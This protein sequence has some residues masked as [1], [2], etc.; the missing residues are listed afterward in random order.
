MCRC[1]SLHTRFSE[2]MLW[3]R[4]SC[5][6]VQETI[7]GVVV[8]FVL[9]VAVLCYVVLRFALRCIVLCFVVALQ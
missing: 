6:V 5:R 2:S 3:L 9:G 1:M 8:V 7:C 4:L